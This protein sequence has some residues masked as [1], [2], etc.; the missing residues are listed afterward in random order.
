MINEMLSNSLKYAFP[1]DRTGVITVDFQKDGDQYTLVVRD[2]GIGL[3]EGFDLDHTE[4]LGLQLV[5]SLVGQI[6][7]TITLN[8]TSGTEFRIAFSLEPTG[9]DHYG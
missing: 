7:G 5:N 4:T 6:L 1:D 8:R 9:G 2:D 3:P